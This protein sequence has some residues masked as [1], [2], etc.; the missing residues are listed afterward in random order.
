M[1]N[2]NSLTY[3]Q[4]TQWPSASLAYS[5]FRQWPDAYLALQIWWVDEWVILF[6]C[7]GGKSWSSLCLKNDIDVAHYNFD[8]DQPILIIIG[9]GVAERVRYQTV[10][11]YLTSPN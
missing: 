1:E 6:R 8:A 11:C 2:D 10:I 3:N 7:G 4:F 9:R 5:Q